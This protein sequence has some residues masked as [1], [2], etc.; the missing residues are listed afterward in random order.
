ML[1]KE[2]IE[3]IM[4]NAGLA[5]DLQTPVPTSER[6]VDLGLDSLD[7]YNIFVELEAQTGIQVPDSDFEKV[8]T[9][10]SLHAYLANR[11]S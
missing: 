1:S 4:L 6:F 2:Q 9:I 10:D 8:Q 11:D 5:V 3:E 7:I